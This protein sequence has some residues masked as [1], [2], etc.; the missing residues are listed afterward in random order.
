ML[1][2]LNT[3]LYGISPLPWWGY[4]LWTLVWMHITLMAVTLY[5]HREQAHRSVD[6]HPALR[7]FFRFWLWITTGAPT[8]EWVAVHRKHHALCERDG[9]PHSPVVFGLKRVVLEGA[10]LY[11]DEARKAETQEKY[12]KGTPDDWLERNV[13]GRF[14]YTGIGILAVFNIVMFG[15]AGIIMLAVQLATM[16]F[17]AA[18][19]INGVCHA[20]GYRNFETS[21]ASTNLWRLGIVIGGEELHNNHH[22]FPTS[23]KFSLRPGELDMGWLH[24]RMLSALGLAKIRRVATEPDL[25]TVDTAPDI[26]TLRSILI[27]RMHVLRAYM[28]RVTLPVLSR[29]CEAQGRNAR[30]L[31]P[32][33]RRW[34]TWQPQ[35]LDE[36]DRQSLGELED[37]LPSFGLVLR[38]RNELKSLWEGAHTSNERLLD[39]F[40]Q[41]CRRA[42]ESGNQ[43]LTEFVDYLRSFQPEAQ[44]A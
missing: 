4:V 34:L 22:A 16:P 44:P 25:G 27:N 35:L 30:S 18:G 19:I 13:Y 36:S 7:H 2:F 10:E 39:D 3:Y 11:I 40:R 32:K 14:D 17:L 21:D 9:D 33:V 41:W 15:A 6:L 31:L 28:H 8:K 29:E 42:E 23:A 24:L 1:D 38:F 20:K 5:F 37:Q 26:E 12:G 43:Y